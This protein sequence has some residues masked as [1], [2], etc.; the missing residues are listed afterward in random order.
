MHGDLFGLAL[1]FGEFGLRGATLFA[2][3]WGGLVLPVVSLLS[4][5][6]ADFGSDGQQAADWQPGATAYSFANLAYPQ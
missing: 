6:V 5:A 4:S 1:T 3:G 2:S